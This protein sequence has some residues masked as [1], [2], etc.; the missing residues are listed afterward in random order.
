MASALKLSMGLAAMLAAAPANA[1]T[2]IVADEDFYIGTDLLSTTIL[3][4]TPD[5]SA[6]DLVNTS[7]VATVKEGISG[8]VE[9]DWRSP[10]QWT[11]SSSGDE[12]GDVELF[13]S[14][15]SGGFGELIFDTLKDTLKLAWGSPDY[16]NKIEFFNDTGLIATIL[17][18][19]VF[20]SASPSR[21]VNF[22]TL[23]MV[24]DV[25]NRIKFSSSQNSFEFSNV[26]ATGPNDAPTVPLPAGLLLLLSG[27]GGL[28]FLSRARSKS[29]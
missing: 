17:G 27:L 18:S 24:D 7:G 16:Y 8:S 22:V 29:A 14:V 2:V 20:Q 3:P 12:Y 28:G 25:F 5:A 10:W 11:K 1:A 13:T 6:P 26:S 15:Q 9:G 4:Y 21:G 19:A 23:L